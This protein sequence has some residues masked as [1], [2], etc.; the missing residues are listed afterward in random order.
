[1]WKGGKG[2]KE[3]KTKKQMTEGKNKCEQQP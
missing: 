1:M 3:K 2:D